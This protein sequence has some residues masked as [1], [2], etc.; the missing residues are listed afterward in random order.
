VAAK[1]SW[2]KP[3]QSCAG[4]FSAAVLLLSSFSCASINF[5]HVRI[6]APPEEARVAQAT[7]G[8]SDLSK[9]LSL[10][11][12]PTSVD[13][14]ENGQRFVLTWNWVEQS[15]WG[16]S[17]SIPIGDQSASFNWKDTETQPQFVQLFFDANWQLVGKA[18]G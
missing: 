10:L 18:E 5:A 15:D 9:C 12:A 2:A 4:L 1:Q 8:E 14:A 7:V 3:W 17:V 13:T 16:F 6:D 11:G